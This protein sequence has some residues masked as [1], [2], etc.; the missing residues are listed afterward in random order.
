[1]SGREVP[2]VE[3][4]ETAIVQAMENEAQRNDGTATVVTAR[5]LV[6]RGCQA[7]KARLH[8]VRAREEEMAKRP[9]NYPKMLLKRLLKK[10]LRQ[11]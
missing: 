7:R 6:T 8:R 5:G 2:A 4:G 9:R 1:M 3:R 10:L 11:P